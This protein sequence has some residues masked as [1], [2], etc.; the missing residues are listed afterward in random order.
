MINITNPQQTRLF[1]SFANVLTEKTRKRLL[2]GWQGVFRHI[3]LELM[4]VDIIGGQFHPTMGR[5]TKEL[6]S[7][8]GLLL[9]KEFK[10]WTKDEALEAYQLDMNIHYAL[11]LEPIANDIGMRTLERYIH[12]FESNDISKAIMDEI[13]VKL[14]DLAGIKIDK[15]R[16]DSTHIYSDM[17]S[18]GRTRLMGVAIKRFLT[19][20]IRSDKEDYNSL[21]ES[22]CQRYASGVNQLF[23]DTKKDSQSHAYFVKK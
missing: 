5:P 15:Q 23:A 12:L 18:F 19:Q 2:D 7:I 16:L 1:D 17:A 4:P 13:T 21:E 20:V 3:I 9:I 10:D 6:Y 11:N 22:L 8:A 14:I